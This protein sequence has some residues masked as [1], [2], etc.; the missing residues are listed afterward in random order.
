MTCYDVLWCVMLRWYLWNKIIHS[1]EG[2]LQRERFKR[3]VSTEDTRRIV[4]YK[5]WVYYHEAFNE[6][7]HRCTCRINDGPKIRTL[8]Y[9]DEQSTCCSA[10][11][12]VFY[13]GSYQGDWGPQ[14]TIMVTPIHGENVFIRCS[15]DIIPWIKNGKFV[16]RVARKTIEGKGA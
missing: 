8:P 13:Y 4:G 7:R 14:P 11:S 15:R 2:D 12:E 10:Y 1:C 9:R 3:L 6:F 16:V 5:I